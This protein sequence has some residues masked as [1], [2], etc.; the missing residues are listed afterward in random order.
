MKYKALTGAELLA[1]PYRLTLNGVADAIHTYSPDYMHG[2]P[3]KDY[4]KL[5]SKFDYK[6]ISENRDTGT[7]YRMFEYLISLEKHDKN[8]MMF[9]QEALNESID[10]FAELD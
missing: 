7:A 8:W 9:L 1:I 5:L 4:L 10:N 2:T 6:T 3:K